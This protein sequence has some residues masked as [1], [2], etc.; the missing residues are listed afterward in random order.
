MR[1]KINAIA[2]ISDQV[3]D[4]TSLF[5]CQSKMCNSEAAKVPHLE[6][7][8]HAQRNSIGDGKN[9]TCL[10]KRNQAICTA[11]RANCNEGETAK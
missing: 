11:C 4:Y 3:I 1:F 2:K 5:H 9:L 7:Q 8:V 6:L 10:W